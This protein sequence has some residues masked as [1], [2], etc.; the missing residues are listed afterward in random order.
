[1][2][3]VAVGEFEGGF[4]NL[5]FSAESHGLVKL[6]KNILIGARLPQIVIQDS[7]HL[8]NF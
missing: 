8:E 3:G 1:V 5:I 2:F 7:F 6:T 4:H